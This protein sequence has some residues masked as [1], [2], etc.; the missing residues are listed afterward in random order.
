MEAPPSVVSMGTNFRV[1]S[2]AVPALLSSREGWR[3]WFARIRIS[4]PTLR[5]TATVSKES[6]KRD[7]GS[8][9]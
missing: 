1:R 3:N 6:G 4:R 8:E 9:Q 5:P 2:V 7:A